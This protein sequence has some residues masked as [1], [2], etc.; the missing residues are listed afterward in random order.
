M[1]RGGLRQPVALTISDGKNPILRATV[2]GLRNEKDTPTRILL[3]DDNGEYTV[4]WA[5][6]ENERAPKPAA[7]TPQ[8]KPKS[9]ASPMKEPAAEYECG[10]A[11]VYKTETLKTKKGD[12]SSHAL[13]F[14]PPPKAECWQPETPPAAA[15]P[16]E[17]AAPDGS[18]ATSA[19]P[20]ESAP[21]VAASASAAPS[22]KAPPASSAKAP[23]KGDDKKQKQP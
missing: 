17:T 13:T 1:M 18:A 5:Q 16:A 9:T 12:L 3:P 10:K 8:A 11:T 22:A 21:T 6:C 4:E 2:L 7:A 14:P 19:A 15:K 23:P 20:A